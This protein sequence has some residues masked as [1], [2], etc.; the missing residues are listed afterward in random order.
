MVG[1]QSPK[2]S[3][4]HHICVSLQVLNQKQYVIFNINKPWPFTFTKNRK[5]INIRWFSPVR[6]PQLKCPPHKH[7]TSRPTTCLPVE[8]AYH[9]DKGAFIQTPNPLS[10][11]LSCP[12]K[13]LASARRTIMSSTN[14]LWQDRSA[15]LCQFSFL[16]GHWTLTVSLL[17][18][19]ENTSQN[20]HHLISLCLGT[21][22]SL[23]WVQG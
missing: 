2:C 14:Y 15:A 8:P 16:F 9:W 13:T 10:S 1:H 20:N 5:I 4:S 17:C 18:L 11:L 23:H 3:M 7:N 22:G 6:G 12:V 21:T 19:V